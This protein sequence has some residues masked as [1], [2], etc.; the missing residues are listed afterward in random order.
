MTGSMVEL[1][2]RWYPLQGEKEESEGGEEILK[3]F[4]SNSE[5]EKTLMVIGDSFRLRLENYMP[6]SLSENHICEN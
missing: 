2:S 4:K 6:Y 1:F 5:N 3:V